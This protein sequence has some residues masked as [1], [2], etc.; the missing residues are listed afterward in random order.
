MIGN[1][2]ELTGIKAKKIDW[3]KEGANLWWGV[4]STERFGLG[5]FGL[6]DIFWIWFVRC[7]SVFPVAVE[8]G[9]LDF[10]DE[11]KYM[12]LFVIFSLLL[13]FQGCST[14]CSS[15]WTNPQAK[16]LFPYLSHT[17]TERNNTY[18]DQKGLTNYI[19]YSSFWSSEN[20]VVVLTNN[21]LPAKCILSWEFWRRFSSSR[22]RREVRE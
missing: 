19:L 5:S 22:K 15:T 2:K 21:I 12:Q 3:K 7:F 6:M 4:N 16:K 1:A 11:T 8:L 17:T 9:S 10:E 13:F 20:Y 14:Q 18:P